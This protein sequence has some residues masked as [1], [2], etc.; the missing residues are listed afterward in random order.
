M[1]ARKV[2]IRQSPLDG[3]WYISHAKSYQNAYGN[4]VNGFSTR[5]KAAAFA[6]VHGDAVEFH[7]VDPLQSIVKKNPA[8]LVPRTRN[9]GGV[10][11]KTAARTQKAAVGYV[12]RASQITKKAP[13]ARLKKRRTVNLQS[14]RGVFPNPKARSSQSAIFKKANEL[15][16]E[17]YERKQAFAIA[18]SEKGE[19]KTRRNPS[20][21][22]FDID[23]NSH[24][25][26]GTKAGTRTNPVSRKKEITVEQSLDKKHWTIFARF[27]DTPDGSKNAVEYAKAYNKKEPYLYLRVMTK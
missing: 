6:T 20:S 17:G 14:A 11:R 19:P 16:R 27:P 10:K 5:A 15:M 21:V 25:A 12:N 7:K 24:N 23:V 9:A 8:P 4:A 22:H 13:S 1:A 26:K 18:Y 2:V 3:L